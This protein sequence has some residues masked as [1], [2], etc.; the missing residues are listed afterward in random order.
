[1]ILEIGV[2][3]L[4]IDVERTK[5]F[6]EQTEWFG[7]G[8]AG[9]RNYEKA[10]SLLPDKVKAFFEQ[11]GVDPGMPAEM[12]VLNAPDRKTILYNGF[13]YICGSLMEGNDPWIQTGSKSFRLKDD[14][15]IH[16]G[17]DFSA[18]IIEERYLLVDTFPR[19]AVQLDVTFSLPWLL[20]EF[21]P[22]M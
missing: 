5:A 8:C 17:E 22:Y 18:H 2:Y 20:D 19:P 11:F 15:Q 21:N 9:C 4:D 10:V 7:C 14:Y 1:M 16:V 3:R 13:F 6:Y 12:S